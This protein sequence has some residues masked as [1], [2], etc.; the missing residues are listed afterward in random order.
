VRLAPPA[1]F[2][3][4][5]AEAHGGS[6]PW[7][8]RNGRRRAAAPAA[9]NAGGC[10][11]F[12]GRLWDEGKNV[13]A[14]DAAAALAEIEVL[15]AGPLEGPQGQ[16]VTLAHARPLG[17]LSS[18]EIAAWLARRPIFAS[19]ALYEPFGLAVLEAAQ[20]GCPLVLSDIATHR[21]LWRD[22]ALYFD[23]RDPAALAALLRWLSAD[24]GAATELGDQALA[25][26]QT[27][28]ADAMAEA[29]LR[30]YATVSPAFSE[31]AR[32]VA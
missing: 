18:D 19:S 10:V 25:R 13:A 20:A 24:S 31:F 2:A 6:R 1:A 28:T 21:E 4:A 12:A 16:R 14:L 29:T 32:R 11:F 30:A 17:A 26:S 8:T 15:A 23:P 3:D 5:T 7:V 9:P 27:Y 22:A